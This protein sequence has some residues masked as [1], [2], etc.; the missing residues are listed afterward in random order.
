VNY[1]SH[2][3]VNITLP[4]NDDL[5]VYLGDDEV[6]DPSSISGGAL[7]VLNIAK[8]APNSNVLNFSV[9]SAAS[10]ADLKFSTNKHNYVFFIQGKQ[11]AKQ[12]LT[13]T[14]KYPKDN[15]Q[16]AYAKFIAG[17]SGKKLNQLYWFSGNRALLPTAVWDDGYFTYFT[18]SK[19]ANIPSIYSVYDA[20]GDEQLE[21][22][23][24]VHNGKWLEVRTLA[25]QFTL[26]I[27]DQWLSVFNQGYKQNGE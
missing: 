17:P 3:V 9:N 25:R 5:T 24:M 27:G 20:E 1:D 15:T 22:V 10:P 14:F 7:N 18:F 23:S 4:F 16:P 21:N 26:R 13:L 6:I 2:N 11:D 19:N 8:P 12:L